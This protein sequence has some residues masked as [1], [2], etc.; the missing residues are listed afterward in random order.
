MKLG[1]TISD[2]T[3][4]KAEKTLK[5]MEVFNIYDIGS[6]YVNNYYRAE[7]Y[8]EFNNKVIENKVTNEYDEHINSFYKIIRGA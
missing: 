2:Y 5:F 3:N 1:S 6:N 4:D 8:E 7:Y